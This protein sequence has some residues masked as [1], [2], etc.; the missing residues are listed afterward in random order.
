MMTAAIFIIRR[1]KPLKLCPG[2][3]LS[4][5]YS[6][7][8][9]DDDSKYS[10]FSELLKPTFEVRA[11]SYRAPRP[12]NNKKPFRNVVRHLYKDEVVFQTIFTLVFY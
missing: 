7:N 6:A 9:N 5:L 11:E 2:N 8:R 4:R 10:K 1:T 12:K 3:F